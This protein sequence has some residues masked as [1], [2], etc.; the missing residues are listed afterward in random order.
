MSVCVG[1]NGELDGELEKTIKTPNESVFMVRSAE[2][3][4]RQ[5]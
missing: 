4:D 3:K 5:F 2:F 1:I